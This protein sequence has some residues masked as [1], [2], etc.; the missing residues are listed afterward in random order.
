MNDVCYI[1]H[2]TKH[3][4]ILH[5]FIYTYI[6][7]YIY[8]YISLWLLCDVYEHIWVETKV[9]MLWAHVSGNPSLSAIS[10]LSPVMQTLSRF[11][12]GVP[13]ISIHMQV[14]VTRVVASE[15]SNRQPRLSTSVSLYFTA[16]CFVNHSE[17]NFWHIPLPGCYNCVLDTCICR[18]ICRKIFFE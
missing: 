5:R 10:G 6:Y 14:W 2:K 11:I 18:L 7:I 1:S 4:I 17:Y 15:C 12:P 13:N 9:H 16:S 8:I 3:N